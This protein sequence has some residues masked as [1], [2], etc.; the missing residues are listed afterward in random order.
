MSF[1][2]ENYKVPTSSNYLKLTEGEHTFR[3]L[4]S[5]IVGWEYFTKENKP[6]RSQDPFE[7]LPDDI[8]DGGKVN[9]FWAF[10][11][12]N[13]DES[14]IQIM[15]ITQKT[16]MFP[17]KSLVD[18]PKWGN[19]QEYDITITRK[20]TGMLDTEYSV[21]PNPHSNVDENILTQ[22]ERTKIDLTALYRGDDP[23]Q[24]EAQNSPVSEDNTET[25]QSTTSTPNTP[26]VPDFG[27]TS[28]PQTT[29]EDLEAINKATDAEESPRQQMEAGMAK[30]KEGK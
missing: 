17:I 11:I 2:P 13:Y 20:G 28:T 14:K 3:V 6:V 21:M 12:W 23:F 16:I 24:N 8:K 19:P 30:A 27:S 4:S 10:I 5:A 25:R 9:P 22:L 7:E 29:Q 26:S 18:N 15:E 1:L